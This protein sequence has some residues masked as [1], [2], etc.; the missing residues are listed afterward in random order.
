MSTSVPDFIFINGK[1]A[2][3][4]PEDAPDTVARGWHAQGYKNGEVNYIWFLHGTRKG[5]RAFLSNDKNADMD[6]WNVVEHAIP[7]LDDA[8]NDTAAN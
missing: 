7:L 8:G 2:A 4:I 6:Q 3:H 5:V 1:N